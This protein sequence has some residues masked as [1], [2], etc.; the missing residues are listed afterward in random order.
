MASSSVALTTAIT[1]FLEIVKISENIDELPQYL[2]RWGLIPTEGVYKCPTCGNSLKL[3]RAQDS[4]DGWSWRC[5]HKVSLRKQA[6][7]VCGTRVAFRTGTVFARSKLSLLQIL[8]FIN[9]WVRCLPQTFVCEELKLS[10]KTAIE[11]ASFCRKVCLEYFMCRPT[12]LGGPGT[13]VEIDESKFGRRKYH[14]GHR[15]EGQCVFGG[16]ERGTGRVFMQWIEPGTTIISNCWKAYD[17]LHHEGYEHLKVN[18]SIT[19]KD[20]ET[21]AHTNSIQSSWR[22]AQPSTSGCIKGHEPGNL[23]RYMFLE[24]CG[25][26]QLDRTLEFFRMAGEL[27]NPVAPREDLDEEWSD[28]GEDEDVIE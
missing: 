13:V 9:L 10:Q 11:W 14:K 15:I 21:V 28:D 7:R 25:I 4:I 5:C 19:F 6:R 23:A 16:F 1:T 8:G 12:K 26:L 18:H 22:A 3:Q 20:P 24:R 17:V 2:Q 27:Y